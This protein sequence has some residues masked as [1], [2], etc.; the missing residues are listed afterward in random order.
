MQPLVD[1][2]TH[3]MENAT[4]HR[5][6]SNASV[7]F[8]SEL[9]EGYG[10]S[11]ETNPVIHEKGSQEDPP[12][13]DWTV[14]AEDKKIWPKTEHGGTGAACVW[15]ETHLMDAN[16]PHG[17]KV[18][19]GSNLPELKA[20][21]RRTSGKGDVAVGILKDMNVVPNEPYLYAKGLIELKT[22]EADLKTGQNMLELM[23]LSTASSFGKAVALLATNCST[24]WEVFHFSDAR[25]VQRKI[26]AHGRKAWEEFAELIRDAEERRAQTQTLVSKAALA[27]HDEEQDIDGFDF[28]APEQ[29]KMKAMEDHAMLERVADYLGDKYGERPVVPLW[30]RVEARCPDYYA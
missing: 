27:T 20:N 16:D 24:N 23:A 26:Y 7:V 21:R 15:F 18:V 2:A 11:C 8:A 17:L 25:T 30:A 12:H 22:N 5:P 1:F 4:V 9:L 6:M 14:V 28:P 29:K 13:Y 10:V 3:S 19:T